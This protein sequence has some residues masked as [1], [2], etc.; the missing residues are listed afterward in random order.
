MSGE[1]KNDLIEVWTAFGVDMADGRVCLAIK[2]DFTLEAS[3][4]KIRALARDLL[5]AAE[6]VD[7]FAKD[8]SL[9][10]VPPVVD[11]LETALSNLRPP[12]SAADYD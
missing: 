5:K 9:K 10:P 11:E 8:G 1:P 3:P 2:P 6:S 4:D 12:R 7:A